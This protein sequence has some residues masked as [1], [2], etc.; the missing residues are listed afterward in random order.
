MLPLAHDVGVDICIDTRLNWF[1]SVPESCAS[2]IN[3]YSPLS[4]STITFA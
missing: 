4:A 3:I 1:E 2:S